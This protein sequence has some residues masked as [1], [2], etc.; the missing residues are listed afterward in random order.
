M[1]F[2]CTGT[3]TPSIK[4]ILQSLIISLVVLES[5]IIL[6]L[7]F[8]IMKKRKISNN[9][10]FLITNCILLSANYPSIC[11]YIFD[12]TLKYNNHMSSLCYSDIESS[13]EPYK[14]HF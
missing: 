2:K 11:T 10:Y 7:L 13:P 9:S 5:K 8:D 14:L 6:L 3:S 1:P 4:K 12:I